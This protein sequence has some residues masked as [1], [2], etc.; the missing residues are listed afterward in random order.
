M[1]VNN[2]H[3]AKYDLEGL[4]Q[5]NTYLKEFV[6]VNQYKIKTIDFANPKAV[7][8]LNKALLQ[9][10]YKINFWNFPDTNLCPPIPSIVDYIHYLSDLAPSNEKIKILDIG[11]GATCIY[12]LLGHRVYNW[13]FVATDIDTKSLETAKNILAENNLQDNIE[14]RLQKNKEHILQG[15][16]QS[17]DN[18]TFSMC[19]PPF[20]KSKFDAIKANTKKRTNLKLDTNSRNFSGN[21]NEL[22]YKGGEKAFLHNYLYESKQFANHFEWFTSLVSKKELVQGMRIS[23]KKLQV[24]TIKVIEMK[25]G[26]KI[27]RILAWQF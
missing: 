12:P 14:L 21:A 22:W 26:N 17:T 23:L 2:I 18:F 24:K 4:S 19:N 15:I 27:T 11:T 3:N 1:H 25:H 8:A 13:D 20:Y 16:I 9:K 6:F 10:H 5:Y 7:K